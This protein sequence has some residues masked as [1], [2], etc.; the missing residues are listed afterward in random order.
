VGTVVLAALVVAL[1]IALV[2]SR[3]PSIVGT[4]DPAV[5]DTFGGTDG[6]TLGDLPG[7]GTWET[8]GRWEV[9]A[10]TTYLAEAP[11]GGGRGYAL[12]PGSSGTARIAATLQGLAD[13]GGIVARYQGPDDHI[14][15][16][17]VEAL[18][19]WRVDVFAGGEAVVSQAMGL[20]GV[21]E[22]MRAELVL[23]GDQAWVIIDG[24]VRGSVDIGAAPDEG[25][26]G[27]VAGLQTGGSTRFDD[28]ARERS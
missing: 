23:R 14:A 7:G 19:T 11:D 3:Q 17:P 26:V 4:S 25:Q 21:E 5:V 15:L 28:V 27:L 8:V 22:G 9:V 2:G 1:L 13:D 6:S 18:G 16:T 20:I 24:Q 10:G 12:L